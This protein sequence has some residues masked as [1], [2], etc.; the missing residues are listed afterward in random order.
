[1]TDLAKVSMISIDINHAGQRLDNFLIS[2]CKGVPKS[3]LYQVI[4][5]G[6][7]RINSKR[8]KPSH[9]LQMNDLVRVPPLRCQETKKQSSQLSLER[10][11]LL[12][13]SVL[14]EDDDYLIIN[15]PRNF[16]VHSGSGIAQGLIDQLK[17]WRDDLAYLQLG[18]R[19]DRETT[20]CLVLAKNRASLLAF[21][22]RL[23]N[24]AVSKQ[25]LALV[26]GAWPE[27][28]RKITA[29]LAR[30]SHNENDVRV[31]VDNSGKPAVTTILDIHYGSQVSL[32]KV[33]LITGRTHQ[34]RVHCQSQGH[35]LL[36][37][38]KYGQRKL[39]QNLNVAPHVPLMLHAQEIAF[40]VNE[41][42]Y[43]VCAQLDTTWQD[44]ASRL[45]VKLFI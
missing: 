23:Q 31:R 11:R 24:S 17:I 7:V 5:T 38:S 16:A 37:D 4:R 6:Q 33:A 18:H 2:L 42:V 27:S 36:G 35:P 30:A 21:Q 25:Y 40:T 34:V 41:R 15:K 19:L 43:Q 28:N 22:R 44:Y 3:K 8:S 10:L 20:G 39:D 32:L 29:A 14:F 13:D 12:N 9:R 1:V 26:H 45:K